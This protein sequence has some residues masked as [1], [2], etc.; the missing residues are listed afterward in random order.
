MIW[1]TISKKMGSQKCLKTAQRAKANLR[2]FSSA[3]DGFKS[4]NPYNKQDLHFIPYSSHGKIQSQID[5]LS[6]PRTPALDLE[7]L[8]KLQSL[9]SLKKQ[10]LAKILTLETGKPINQ[11]IAELEKCVGHIG[12]WIGAS[13]GGKG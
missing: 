9:L 5:Q 1:N 4:V 7:K 10:Q 8:R 13:K 2:C 3:Q 11:S 12:T 6:D